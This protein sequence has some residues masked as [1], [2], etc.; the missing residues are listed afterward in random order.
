MDEG[1]GV[2]RQFE[3]RRLSDPLVYVFERDGQA[4]QPPAFRRQ[5][6]DFWITWRDDFGWG[7]WNGDVLTGRPRDTHKEAQSHSAPPEGKWVSQK[8]TKSYTYDLVHTQRATK[9][10]G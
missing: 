8:G 10:E 3:L 6:G 1:V 5:D 7:A 4:G 2:V 9:E